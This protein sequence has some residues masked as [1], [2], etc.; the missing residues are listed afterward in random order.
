[1]SEPTFDE[2]TALLGEVTGGHL[3]REFI[4]LDVSVPDLEALR[5]SDGS[6]PVAVIRAPLVC[7]EH[8]RLLVECVVLA[9]QSAF[10]PMF[11]NCQFVAINEEDTDE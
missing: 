10:Q 4:E 7:V 2:W 3:N 1:M 8:D 6:L 9:M 5:F 11:D